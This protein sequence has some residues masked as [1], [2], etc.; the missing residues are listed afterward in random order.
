[1]FQKRMILGG[2]LRKFVEYYVMLCAHKALLHA[3][4][5]LLH[6]RNSLLCARNS[7]LHDD[8]V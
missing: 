8:N 5:A 1:M 3:H 6:A 2:I 7:L 4:K